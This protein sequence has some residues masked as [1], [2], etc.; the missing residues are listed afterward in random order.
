MSEP[1]AVEQRRD[2]FLIA[3][4]AGA[5]LLIVVGIGAVLVVGRTPRSAPADP[6]SAEG[7]VK[8]YVEAIQAGDAD[9]AYELLSQAAKA[10]TSLQEYRQRFPRNQPPTDSGQRVL[11][12]AVEVGGDTA[13]VR[14]T[15]SHFSARP[16]PFSAGSSHRAVNVR[17]IREDG[18]WRVSQ[19]AEPFPLAY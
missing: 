6:T 17:L 1:A 7:V 2:P 11:I 12:E 4:V 5:L 19:P 9:G 13:D 18:A 10:S 15:F 3:I 14:V 8:A 16:E